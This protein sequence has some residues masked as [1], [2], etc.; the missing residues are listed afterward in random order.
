MCTRSPEVQFRHRDH[1]RISFPAKIPGGYFGASIEGS[2]RLAALFVC[3]L[4]SCI[5]K[6]AL[7]IA[8]APTPPQPSGT[9][10]LHRAHSIP[11]MRGL[12]VAAPPTKAPATGESGGRQAGVVR[13]AS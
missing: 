9:K 2:S 4:I 7:K 1:A 5:L 6:I 12:I 3:A 8:P 11:A 13:A 10:Y